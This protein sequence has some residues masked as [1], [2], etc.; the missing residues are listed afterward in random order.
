MATYTVTS[1]PG[2]VP[3]STPKTLKEARRDSREARRQGLDGVIYRGE[4][5]VQ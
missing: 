1:K 3:W 5:R 4:T 2:M